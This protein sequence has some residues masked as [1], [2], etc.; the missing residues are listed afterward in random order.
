MGQKDGD[1]FPGGGHG[2][3]GADGSDDMDKTGAIS[4]DDLR[5]VGVL[6][7]EPAAPVEK[8]T[9]LTLD[10]MQ[11]AAGRPAAPRPP[12]GPGTVRRTGGTAP[13]GS[14][15]VEKTTAMTLEEMR[16]AGV[17]GV[18]EAAPPVEKT[19]AMTL[20]EMRRAGVPGVGEA[21]PPVEKTTAMTLDEMRRAGV[22]G[23][24]EAAPPVEK[25][26]AMTLDE[27]RGGGGGGGA[28]EKTMAM[29]LDEMRGEAEVP[30]PTMLLDTGGLPARP[31]KL[32]AISGN[33][34]GTS[35]ELTA[36]QTLVG[37][38]LDCGIVLNDA[39]VSRKHFRI[40]RE[41][42]GWKLVDLGSGNGTKVDGQRVAAFLALEDGM[43]IEAGTTQLRWSHVVPKARPATRPGGAAPR[44]EGM[45]PAQAERTIAMAPVTAGARPDFGSEPVEERTRI[46]DMAA[47]EVLPEWKERVESGRAG[48]ADEAAAEAEAAPSGGGGA[49]KWVAIALGLISLL[50]GGFV[51]ADKVAGLGIVFPKAEPVSASAEATEEA[52]A[53]EEAEAAPDP[54][55]KEA[56]DR[57]LEQFKARRWYE[58]RE[59][60][61]EAV[62]LDAE[63]A[64]ASEALAQA[65]AE[66]AASKAIEDAD[67]ATEEK[68]FAEAIERL[69]AVPNTSSYYPQSRE[70]LR[71][72][73]DGLV[74]RQL[75]DARELEEKGELVGALGAVDV[76]LAAAPEDADA[77]ALREELKQAIVESGGELPTS[78]EL[79]AAA[80]EAGAGEAEGAEEPAGEEA[81]A[82]AAAADDKVA[83]EPAAE[84]APAKEAAVAE[85]PATARSEKT[86]S[87]TKSARPKSVASA[88][89]SAPA[90]KPT[91]DMATGL[92]KYAA[93]DLAGAAAAFEEASGHGRKA[94][95][96][97]AARLASTVK[98][99]RAKWES[100]MAAAKGYKAT[101]AITDLTEAR[102]LDAAVSGAH[103]SAIKAELSKQHSYLANVA[104]QRE[105]FGAAG[106]HARKA[107]ALHSDQP[108]AQ[109]IYDEVQAKAQTW[110]QDAKGMA[111]S[112]PGAAMQLLSKV[113]AVFPRGDSRY[114]E[115]Y[116]LL[117][118]LGAS[119]THD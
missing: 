116:K 112:N 105:D 28:P 64:G 38:G 61:K 89:K 109:K 99:F 86:A 57:G 98:K 76:A 100:G 71:A 66:V 93:L 55:A 91:G 3:S 52:A 80:A 36:E 25:T 97:K 19:T 94:D 85:A 88:R 56:M 7:D 75:G 17:P 82:E 8:T 73:R 69:K 34:K 47:L 11:R 108:S 117:N 78:E 50:G 26:T 31:P 72:A 9:A 53:E 81:P 29:T 63:L 30:P 4:L 119:G 16:R 118:E 2:P 115:A 103:Q 68:K 92:Q 49:L 74:E 44:Q 24:G 15:P 113:L 111:S 46:G 77:L 13:Q 84:E 101:Q 6:G 79:A 14:A 5:R 114:A 58:A 42:D 59:S 22:P 33:D 65:E 90:R 21:A 110:L 12:A 106:N 51:I 18:G 54:K 45:A 40:D 10:E 32:E 23:V 83:E 96:A 95:R 43:V 104:Y 39:S 60:F 70:M 107:L 87:P 1:G 37:R 41:G 62:K 27:M 102:K 67:K 35:Y 48:G 20:D